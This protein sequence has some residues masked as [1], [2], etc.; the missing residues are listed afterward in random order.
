MNKIKLMYDV[1]KAMKEKE[2]FIGILE[3]VAKKDQR[4]FFTFKNEF[5]KNLTTGLVKLKVNTALDMDGKQMKH[6]SSSEFNITNCGGVR[7][8]HLGRPLHHHQ[9]NNMNTDSDCCHSDLKG[10]LSALAFAFSLLENVKIEELENKAL[11]VTLAVDEIPE[12]LINHIHERF[13]HGMAN[14]EMQGQE[15][16]LC[17]KEFMGM[18]NLLIN[19]NMHLTPDKTIESIVVTAEGKQTDSVGEIHE[20][21]FKTELNMKW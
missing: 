14:E 8:H 12:N 16:H 15:Q 9:C 1:A 2:V 11:V 6:E 10:K 17:M 5:D 3:T 19:L 20:M 21:N 18:E 13:H 7:H 4:E